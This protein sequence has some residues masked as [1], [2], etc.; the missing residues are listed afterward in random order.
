MHPLAKNLEGYMDVAIQ[1]GRGTVC[2]L[3]LPSGS[4][5]GWLFRQS[6]SAHGYHISWNAQEMSLGANNNEH[7]MMDEALQLSLQPFGSIIPLG[8]T[9]YLLATPAM[10]DVRA[11][12]LSIARRLP[13]N[14]I[15]DNR[16]KTSLVRVEYFG[17]M[18]E[19]IHRLESEIPTSTCDFIVAPAAPP[20]ESIVRFDSASDVQAVDVD[21][22]KRPNFVK[23]EQ[24]RIHPRRVRSTSD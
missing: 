7:A 24:S 15:R 19:F 18:G 23:L 13:S 8:G 3:H 1:A 9:A 10:I 21:R 20:S 4:L 16:W 14:L 22:V 5:Q 12:E 6:H 17:R 2:S 11:I